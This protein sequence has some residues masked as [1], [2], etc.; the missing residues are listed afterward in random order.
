V[1]FVVHSPR[2]LDHPADLGIE[3]FEAR[4]VEALAQSPLELLP[5]EVCAALPL[6]DLRRCGFRRVAGH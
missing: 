6:A 4:V 3:R 5:T 2:R 1:I